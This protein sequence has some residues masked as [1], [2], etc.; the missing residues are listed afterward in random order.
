LAGNVTSPEST[1]AIA[2]PAAVIESQSAIADHDT[3]DG[4]TPLHCSTYTLSPSP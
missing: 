1:A 4:S 3:D 2:G